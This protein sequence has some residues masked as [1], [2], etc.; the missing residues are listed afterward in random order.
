VASVSTIAVRLRVYY[1]FWSTLVLF[2]A[3]FLPFFFSSI[4]QFF[5]DSN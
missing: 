5:K 4:A 1:V 3:Y 2:I